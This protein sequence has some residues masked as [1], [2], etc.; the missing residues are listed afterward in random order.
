MQCPVPFALGSFAK[1]IAGIAVVTVVFAT[2]ALAHSTTGTCLANTLCIDNGA[3]SATSG[4]GKAFAGLTLNTS[5]VTLVSGGPS[6]GYLAGKDLGNVSFTTG[7]LTSGTLGG[8][9]TFGAGSITITLTTPYS[10]FTGVL[11][12]G[13]FGSATSGISWIAN[14]KAG[15]NY[16]YELV[17]PVSGTF[18]GGITVSGETAQFFFN[19]KKPFDG[20]TISLSSGSTTLV[21]PEPTV[22][23]LMGIGMVGIAFVAKL[24]ARGAKT[25]SMRTAAKLVEGLI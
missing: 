25:R 6:G 24:K 5:P 9:G 2:A 14:G 19:S 3:G 13:T 11:F 8:G 17:G 20:G 10:G 22:L 7:G 4:V 15:S 23:G 1:K 12:T 18:E 21:T 16:Q